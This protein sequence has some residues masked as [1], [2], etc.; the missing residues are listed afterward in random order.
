MF[1][2]LILYK[3]VKSL[4]IS[5]ITKRLHRCWWRMFETK[6]VIDNFEMLVTVLAVFV[7]NIVYLSTLLT[8]FQ[9]IGK[10]FILCWWLVV[11]DNFRMLATK[12]RFWWRVYHGVF[13]MLVPNTDVSDRKCWLPKWS[14][15]SPT[16]Y[17]CHQHISSPTSVTNISSPTLMQLNLE[18]RNFHFFETVPFSLSKIKFSS[19]IIGSKFMKSCAFRIIFAGLVINSSPLII[20]ICSFLK[21]ISS[22]SLIWTQYK[23]FEII[24]ASGVWLKQIIMWRCV[25]TLQHF[26]LIETSQTAP[27]ILVTNSH[28]Q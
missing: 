8:V 17:N 23:P 27:R 14:K 28:W 5:K 26:D 12:L 15:P 16:S 6:C 2:T 3:A 18:M 10:S 4:F 24:D 9:T 11:G 19:L 25:I 1:C 13:K 21:P 20:I 22:H 7:T